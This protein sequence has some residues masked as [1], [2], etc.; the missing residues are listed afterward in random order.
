MKLIHKL[1]AASLRRKLIRQRAQNIADIRRGRSEARSIRREMVRHSRLAN[2]AQP[3]GAS[4]A[5]AVEAFQRESI[6]SRL[7]SAVQSVPQ[8]TRRA[9]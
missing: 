8:P 5:N 2:T 1:K 4:S 9:A 6:G 7:R 3:A